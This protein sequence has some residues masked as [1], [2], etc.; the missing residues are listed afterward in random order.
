MRNPVRITVGTAGQAAESIEQHIVPL[1]NDD[2]KWGWL[3]PRVE[4]LLQNGQML[5][6]VKSKTS[7]EDLCQLF[8]EF[9]ELDTLFLHGDMDQ[10]ERLQILHQFRKSK[11]Q[12]LVATDVAARGLDIPTI[13]TVLSY[14]SPRDTETY[15]HRIGRTGRAGEKGVAYTLLTSE[16]CKM[17][18]HLVEKL[19]TEGHA[20]AEDHLALANQHG[21]FRGARLA[22][23]KFTAKKTGGKGA[24]KLL[25][26]SGLGFDGNSG[27]KNAQELEAK[28]NAEADTQMRINRMKMMGTSGFSNKNGK[29]QGPAGFVA[30][31]DGLKTSAKFVPQTESD[32]DE[33]LFAPGVTSAFGRSNKTLPK[34]AEPA[35][36]SST[37][38]GGKE[39]SSWT[40]S[41]WVDS[42]S[43]N[44]SSWKSNDASSS[45]SWTSSSGQGY[46]VSSSNSW[47]S[48][49]GKGYDIS[50]SNQ[51]GATKEDD[52]AFS[53]G[54]WTADKINALGASMTGSAAGSSATGS[55][56]QAAKASDNWWDDSSKTPAASA[57]GSTMPPLIP[58][59]RTLPQTAPVSRED[60]PD[61]LDP[62]KIELPPWWN[63]PDPPGNPPAAPSGLLEGSASTASPSITAAP[64]MAGATVPGLA[65]GMGGSPSMAG[66]FG[67]S[68]SESLAAK[69]EKRKRE[70]AEAGMSYA[71]PGDSSAAEEAC[72]M[73]SLE[74]I[75][76]SQKR[77]PWQKTPDG[78][79][80]PVF[81]VEAHGSIGRSRGLAQP[82]QSGPPPSLTQMVEMAEKAERRRTRGRSDSRKRGRSDSRRRGRSD[83]RR[84][85]RRR[86]S[87]RSSS[88]G[89]QRR[90]R[91]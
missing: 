84:R 41:G 58:P 77:A 21:A 15:T 91:R 39:G 83:S 70:V 3:S 44:S 38:G 20:V 26:T 54:G 6:F 10:G 57:S 25:S 45:K 49:S 36:T 34:P 51:K 69:V 79:D 43:W 14:D 37:D 32:S 78:K 31:T 88:S 72:V 81:P 35:Q 18:A 8:Q 55:S 7:A 1:K 4:P 86:S 82:A 27:P 50:S 46:E 87:S 24:G 2:E 19:E 29:G 16:D 28:L 90:K 17:A 22:G 13:R 52:D 48:D 30:S 47:T 61:L 68:S 85:K 12:V 63:D 9:L 56:S 89:R 33:D 5:I 40:D 11:V 60:N 67:A 73:D 64:G 74:K 71:T 65:A 80:V 53:F 75:L 23:E 59:R 66:G 62:S 76:E 42:S